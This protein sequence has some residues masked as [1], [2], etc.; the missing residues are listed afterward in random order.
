MSSAKSSGEELRLRSNGALDRCHR[1]SSVAKVL[2]NDAS[3]SRCSTFRMACN[4]LQDL[5][6]NQQHSTRR[7]IVK[8]TSIKQFAVQRY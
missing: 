6:E 7:F 4:A 8:N 3:L 5:M 1:Q 2:D